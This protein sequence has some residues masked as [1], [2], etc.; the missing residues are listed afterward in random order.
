VRVGKEKWENLRQISGFCSSS[1]L[2]LYHYYV[3]RSSPSSENTIEQYYNIIG[4]R[5][6]GGR[7]TAIKRRWP[8]AFGIM[9]LSFV[10]FLQDEILIGATPL[11]KR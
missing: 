8:W 4:G 3:N 5:D 6:Y 1:S 7:N 11:L 9:P 10:W 2:L